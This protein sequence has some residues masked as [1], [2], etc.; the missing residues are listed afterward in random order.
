[1]TKEELIQN[2]G[3]VAKSGTSQFV[4]A[5]ASGAD[6]GLIGQFGV[7]FYSVYLVAD[8]VRVVSKN[9]EDVQCVWESS[10]D[11]TFTVAEDP[12]GN[13]LGRGTEITLSLKD[14]ASEYLNQDKLET[15]IKRY[16]EFITFPIHLHKFKT[17]TVEVPVEK[18]ENISTGEDA[19]DEEA[20]DRELQMEDADEESEEDEE[21]ATKTET[22]KRWFWVQVNQNSAIWT[23][24]RSE[25]T[26]EEYKNF[27]KG[28]AKDS[29]DPAAWI[30]FKAEGEIEFRS[31]LF[32]PSKAPYNMYDDYYSTK[33]SL[34]LYVR[35]VLISDTFEDLLPRYLS[36]VKGVVDSDDLPLNVSRETLQQ[37]K[38]LKV[39][40]KKL[41]RKTLEMLRKL[42]IRGDKAEKGQKEEEEEEADAPELVDE[43]EKEEAAAKEAEKQSEVNDYIKFWK[44]F[45]KSLKLGIIEDSSN[46]S[47]LSKL[48]RF[49]TTKSGDR[50]ISF[51]E[52][53][54]NMKDWQKEIYFIAAESEEVALESPF[55]E[56][57]TNKDLEVILFTDPIDEYALQNLPEYDGYNLQSITKEDVK[58]GDEE[59]VDKKRLEIYKDNF[60]ALSDWLEDVYGD[61]IDKVT[62][63]GRPS[64]APAMLVTSKF[65]Y[66]A[67]M[68]RIIR[69][70]AF[71]DP[72][73]QGYMSSRKTME[74]NPRHPIV[75]KLLTLVQADD[76]QDAQNTKDVAWALYDAALLNSGFQMDD[77]KGFS[78]RMFRLMQQNLGL[79]NLELEPELEVTVEEEEEEY[80]YE[81]VEEEEIV[82]EEEV[83]EEEEEE[84][85]L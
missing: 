64:A 81:E 52:Y 46:R 82:E 2:L 16:S 66:S 56:P 42:A 23:R 41:V 19:E 13:T 75:T 80:E 36:F 3:T 18:E 50:L 17:E 72:D 14:D 57:F 79:E 10:A 34:R 69:A 65:G 27:Y 31:I 15:L 47:K 84:E 29:E 25:I 39:I 24:D 74:L 76:T 44:Q 26:G 53:V 59:E 85:E 9:N 62:V 1:M 43:D 67:N 63:S 22:I 68:E 11:G 78:E 48:L 54:S 77:S 49:K 6:V 40:G 35:K 21:A 61:K 73:K 70:Q 5:M 83:V 51:A 60:V 8:K 20:E 71:N 33:T 30:H 38:V 32:V 4:E 45:G 55:L 12:R 7:G 58:F 28:I 37:H